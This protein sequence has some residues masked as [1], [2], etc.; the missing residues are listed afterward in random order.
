MLL[1]PFRGAEAVALGVVCGEGVERVCDDVLA[2][3]ADRGVVTKGGG[4]AARSVTVRE[5]GVGSGSSAGAG[6][7]DDDAS[8]SPSIIL[9]GRSSSST[10]NS[11]GEG[12]AVVGGCWIRG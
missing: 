2:L 9:V 12:R 5:V 10:L 3:L 4:M 8:P 1:L 6:A 11:G 7:G